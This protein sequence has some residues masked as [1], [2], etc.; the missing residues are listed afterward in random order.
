MRFLNKALSNAERLQTIVEDLEA[1]S[2]LESDSNEM[3]PFDI[4]TFSG[5]FFEDLSTRA[6]EK[7]IKTYLQIR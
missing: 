4:H 5:N 6:D 1:I 3:I 2:K 7:N